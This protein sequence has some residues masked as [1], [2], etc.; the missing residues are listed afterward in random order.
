MFGYYFNLALRSLRR[1]ITLTVL[2]IVAI[3]IGIGASM[4]MLTVFR[5]ASGDPIPQKSAQL[6]VPQLDNFG[7]QSNAPSQFSDLLVPELTYTDATALMRAHTAVRQAAMYPTL[8]AVTP[9]DPARNPIQ[10][11]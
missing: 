5:A 7:P 3:G 2:M 10:V 6:F 11:N 4:T 8:L 9:S 1:N